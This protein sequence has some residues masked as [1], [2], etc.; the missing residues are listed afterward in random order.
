M[1]TPTPLLKLAAVETRIGAYH[2]LHGVDFEVPRGQL[3][4]LLGRN[5]AGKTTT[6]RTIM[7]LWQPSAG[8]VQ[9]D[10]RDIGGLATPEIARLGIAYV[11]ESM[12][13][14]AD[15]SVRDNMV[16]AARGARR[17]EDIDAA[18]LDWIFSLF[19]AMKT[20][21]LHPA[22]KLSGGQ[23]QMLAVSRAIVEPRKLIL[24][25]EPS[26]GLAPAIIAN[27]I[28]AFRELKNTDTTILLVEQNFNFAKQLGDTV[29]VMDDGRIVHRGAMAE[30]AEDQDL[31]TRLLG[32]SLAAH[33]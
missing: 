22:G 10:G 32:L 24:I 4:M 6:L 1:T 2:I 5:G 8:S 13:I 16:L 29:A 23:K 20:F 19:P 17:A 11:P 12:G 18:R 15:L 7:G 27:M 9:F 30:L 25:D 14:F 31:Q 26:K 21:W 3:T 28:A 33:Q